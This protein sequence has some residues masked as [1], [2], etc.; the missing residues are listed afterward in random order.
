MNELTA[1]HY[2]LALCYVLGFAEQAAKTSENERSLWLRVAERCNEA[3]ATAPKPEIEAKTL[4]GPFYCKV[5]GCQFNAD[6]SP[7][8]LEHGEKCGVTIH[9]EA[10]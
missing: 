10:V 6:E 1:R 8:E 7:C 9:R 3:F 4:G 2:E 5:C